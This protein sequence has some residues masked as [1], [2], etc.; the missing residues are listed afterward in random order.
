MAN[1]N[2]I[3]MARSGDALCVDGDFAIGDATLEHQKDLLYACKGEYKQNPMI[4]VGI[5]DFLNAE[6]K[7]TMLNEIR[8]QFTK[9]GMV[10]DS[11]NI[12]NGINIKAHYQ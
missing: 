10:I 5:Y 12:N 11:I 2:D 8:S 3:L 7:G 6:D 1:T 4:G 9:D